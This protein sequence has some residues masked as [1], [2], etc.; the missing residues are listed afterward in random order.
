[1]KSTE[2]MRDI[3]E[4]Q[5]RRAIVRNGMQFG[6]FGYIEID[7][8]AL[9]VNRMNG[10]FRRRTQLAYILREKDKYEHRKEKQV[11]TSMSEPLTGELK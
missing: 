10:G 2:K 11:P 6:P 9:A 5:F 7:G 8:G 1:M 3:S 4:D